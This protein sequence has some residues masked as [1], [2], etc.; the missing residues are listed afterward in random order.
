MFA[1]ALA[2]TEGPQGPLLVRAQHNRQLAHPQKYLWDVLAS[3]RGGA[4]L[5][6]LGPRP[7]GP[8]GRLA[9]LSIR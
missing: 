5:K 7:D 2:P 8:P 3:Q 6:I 1:P 4:R 9:T